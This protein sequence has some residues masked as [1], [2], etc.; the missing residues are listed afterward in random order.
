MQA[1]PCHCSRVWK[2]VSSCA[3]LSVC[4]RRG[5]RQSRV[6]CPTPTRPHQGVSACSAYSCI[7]YHLTLLTSPLTVPDMPTVSL[8]HWR[9]TLK[10]TTHAETHLLPPFSRALSAVCQNLS[11]PPR[12]RYCRFRPTRVRCNPPTRDMPY[13]PQCK[14]STDNEPDD[15]TLSY[16]LPVQTECAS[17]GVTGSRPSSACVR[18]PPRRT[19]TSVLVPCSTMRITSVNTRSR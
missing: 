10:A 18:P 14:Q 13:D 9:Q 5:R 3:S 12:P 8:L 16:T 19:L 11:L 15:S 4:V 7:P 1:C 2:S 17:S 6:R